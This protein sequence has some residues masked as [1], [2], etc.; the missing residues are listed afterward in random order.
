MI[1]LYDHELCADCYKIRLLLGLLGLEWETRRIDFHP[2]REHESEWFLRINPLGRI[3]VIVDGDCTLRDAQAIL[4]YLAAKYDGSGRWYPVADARTCAEV[5]MWLAFAGEL[6]PTASAARLHEGFAHDLDV[7]CARSGAHR[8][9]RGA[10][11]APVV[12]RA[13]GAGLA[14]RTRAS[15]RRRHRLLPRRHALG[16]RRDLAHALPRDP[17]MDGSGETDSGLRDDAGNLS[18]LNRALAVLRKVGRLRTTCR[19]E[20]QLDRPLPSAES[21]VSRTHPVLAAELARHEGRAPASSSRTSR[22]RANIPPRTPR[23]RRSIPRR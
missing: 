19:F 2:G 7:D 16:G 17:P 21:D 22:S 23:V 6:T 20:R 13:G 5:A 18:R 14:V 11:R 1:R 15:D 8:L 4:V 10:R 9:F 3:P 12:R